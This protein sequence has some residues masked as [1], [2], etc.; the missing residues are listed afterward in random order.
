MDGLVGTY[1]LQQRLQRYRAFSPSKLGRLEME[2]NRIKKDE[3]DKK[4]SFGMDL[5]IYVSDS[6][7]R[8][9]TFV[10]I[11]PDKTSKHFVDC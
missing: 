7:H 10:N 8:L 6:I 3:L 4:N 9:I 11:N 5:N 2:P 1:Y